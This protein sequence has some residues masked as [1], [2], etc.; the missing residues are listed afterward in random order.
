MKIVISAAILLG[1]ISSCVLNLPLLI[2]QQCQDEEAMVADYKK[3]LTQFVETA[4]K[5]SQPEFEKTFHQKVCLT[6]LTLCLSMLNEMVGCLEKAGADSTATKEQAEAYKAKRDAY[7]K[8]KDKVEE[9]RKTLK[10]AEDSKTA[11]ALIEKFD[12]PN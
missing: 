8:F 3:D 2:A 4:R 10:A 6:K 9:Y 5:E 1:A 7:T 11:K 12:F